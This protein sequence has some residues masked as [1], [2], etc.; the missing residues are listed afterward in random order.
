MRQAVPTFSNT[1]VLTPVNLKI[2]LKNQKTH[3]SF[4][5]FLTLLKV[6]QGLRGKLKNKSSK[7]FEGLLRTR[8]APL[9]WHIGW[10]PLGLQVEDTMPSGYFGK[11]RPRYKPV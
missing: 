8:R 10:T 9:G 2:Q 4:L 11:L 6:I 7:L 3:I 5:F 1:P